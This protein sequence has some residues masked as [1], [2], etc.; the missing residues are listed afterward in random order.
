MIQCTT[1]KQDFDPSPEQKK[2]IGRAAEKGMPFVMLKC[3]KCWISFGYYLKENEEKAEEG[4]EKEL[5]RC[6]VSRC[7]GWV[8]YVSGSPE[9][10]TPFWGCGEC[11]SMWFKRQSLSRDIGDIIKKYPYRSPFYVLENGD[12]LPSEVHE[13]KDHQARVEQEDD[14]HAPDFIRD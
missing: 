12:Y 9:V 6:P 11:G 3:P 10:E 8:S 4:C 2:L 14:D 5:V 1:C 13:I 7:S